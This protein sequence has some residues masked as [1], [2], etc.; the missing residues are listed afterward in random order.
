MFSGLTNQVSGLI[1]KAKGEQQP[2]DE[3]GAVVDNGA[4]MQQVDEN[5]EEVPVE[6]GQPGAGGVAGLAQGFM[7]KAMSAKD[8]IKEKAAGFQPPNLQGLGNNLMQNVTNLIPGKKEED[9]PTPP[10]PNP[11]SDM[12]G[13]LVEGEEQME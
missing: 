10:E 9:V 12:G 2:T 5:G 7:A 8:G 4:Q 11:P 3:D 1:A 6:G 13:E